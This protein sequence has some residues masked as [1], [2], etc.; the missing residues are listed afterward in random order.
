MKKSKKRLAA[1]ALSAVAFASVFSMGAC[2]QPTKEIINAYDI[3]VK[4]GFVGTEEEWLL[5]LHGSNGKDGES[6][7]IY[8]LY[9]AAKNSEQGYSGDILQFIKD[10][11][12]GEVFVLPDNN[13]T[14]LIAKN[15]ASVVSVVCAFR[16]P[17]NWY[18]STRV[19]K[20]GAAAGSGV[21]IDYGFNKTGGCAYVV[22][23][24]HVVFDPD[25]DTQNKISDCIYLYSYGDLVAFSSGD[26][27][28]DGYLD[29]VNK[30]GVRDAK[31]QGDVNNGG[32]RATFVGG[33]MDYDI[34]ILKIE[35]SE[36]LKT[37]AVEPAKWGTPN[38]LTLGEKVFAVGNAN[39]EGIAVTQ[40]VVSVDSETITMSAFDD[41]D[42]NGDK[43][44]DGVSF[45]VLRTS[46]EINHGNSGG[47]LFNARGE[48][49]GITNAKSTKEDTEGVFYALPIA[50]VGYLV[51]N[52]LNNVET[53]VG[54]FATR[55]ML[56]VRT[57]IRD[58]KMQI[59]DG[60]NV[61]KET[62]ELLDFSGSTSTAAKG[63]LQVGDVFQKVTMKDP[64]DRTKT[65]AFIINRQ[66]E[67]NDLLLSVRKGDVVT[68]TILR[69]DKE[70]DVEIPFDKDEYFIKYA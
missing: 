28:G 25:A 57:G 64:E 10:Y 22:T 43:I 60:R 14:S 59:V 54:G 2:E 67:I 35:G 1:L 26:I 6:L 9:E 50:T 58:S 45:R 53:G 48:L 7:N 27:T 39:G 38:D 70:I 63:K 49:I 56:G 36:R 20:V 32:Y 51:G 34:A 65:K 12:S 23:N 41:R 29:D 52:I 61:I 47:G 40:G 33:A 37:S 69:E 15:V 8:D 55:A 4:N 31:D 42:Q 11:L 13:A 16:E 62:I 3:A 19:P 30:D 17:L 68:F 5:S 21:I 18:D 44:V 66:F 46:A 24:Y